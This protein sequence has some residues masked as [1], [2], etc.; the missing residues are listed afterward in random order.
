VDTPPTRLELV[1]ATNLTLR[2]DRSMTDLYRTRFEGRPPQVRATGDTVTLEYPR[3]A[4]G[5][6]R[7][8]RSTVTLGTA[9]PWRIE[10]HGALT[11]LTADLT[12]ITLVA[13]DVHQ[14]VS[15]MRVTLPRPS[16]KIPIQISGGAEDARFHRPAGVP[17]KVHVAGG[18]SRLALDEQSFTAVGGGFEW[19]TPEW[20]RATGG[21]EISIL[22][23]VRGLVVDSVDVAEPAEGRT[24]RALATVVFTDIVRSTERAREAGDRRWREVLDRHDAAAARLAAAARGRVVKT[25]GDGILAVFDEPGDG[26][27][28]ARAFRDEAGTLGVEIRTGVHTGEVEY[29]GVDVGGIAVHIGSRIMDAAG[30]DEILVSR[31]VRELV[32]GSDVELQDRGSRSLRGVGDDWHLFAVI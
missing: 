2:G 31:T 17:V 24:G 5:R 30:S 9:T 4:L 11:E 13:L 1:R 28:F 23:G 19:Q 27:A 3:F 26:I 25:T 10:C 22:R 7:A 6:R 20:Q 18:V 12:A 21:Y 14:G 15:G 29:R 8:Y 32:A 16:G